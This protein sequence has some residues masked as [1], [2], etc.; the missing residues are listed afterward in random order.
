[1]IGGFAEAGPDGEHYNSAAVVDA[2]GVVV[3]YRKTHLWDREKLWFRPG[4][5]LPPVIDTA[6]G[7]IGVAICYD[8]EF[9]EL[10]RHL[11]VR[12]R[13]ARRGADQLAARASTGRTS[14][15]PRS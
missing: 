14:D 15:R 10:M 5:Q 2:D 1:M 9:P 11:A 3:V 12:R 7:R 6:H 8:L 13:R 4:E